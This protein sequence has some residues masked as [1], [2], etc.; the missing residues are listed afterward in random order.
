MSDLETA[1]QRIHLILDRLIAVHDLID[2]GEFQTAGSDVRELNEVL[3]YVDKRVVFDDPSLARKLLFALTD[4]Q[5]GGHGVTENLLGTCWLI[6][7]ALFGEVLALDFDVLRRRIPEFFPSLILALNVDGIARS[8]DTTLEQ[9]E[10][11]ERTRIYALIEHIR[12]TSDY[13]PANAR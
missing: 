5:F 8:F 7:E 4:A 2:D 3:G 1:R 12:A 13:F 10:P 6:P 11:A 9:A